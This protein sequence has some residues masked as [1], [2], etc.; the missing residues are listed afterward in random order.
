MSRSRLLPSSMPWPGSYSG[1]R[2]PTTKGAGSPQLHYHYCSGTA[3][4][5]ATARVRTGDQRHSAV[6]LTVVGSFNLLRVHT[7][8][9]SCKVKPFRNRLA[10]RARTNASGPLQG[11]ST[12]ERRAPQGNRPGPPPRSRRGGPPRAETCQRLRAHVHWEAGH[13]DTRRCAAG[14]GPHAVADEPVARLACRR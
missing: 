8:K 10:P 12:Q 6:R 14:P 5:F 13:D 4:Q 1:P 9:L 11:K 2:T 3:S 7:L